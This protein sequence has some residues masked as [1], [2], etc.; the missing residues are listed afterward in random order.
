MHVREI[1]EKTTAIRI[2]HVC[3]REVGSQREKGN[4]FFINEWQMWVIS[5]QLHEEVQES[6]SWSISRGAP[7]K[8]WS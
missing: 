2:N 3:V 4:R 1:K 7:Q 8:T 6:K 5:F